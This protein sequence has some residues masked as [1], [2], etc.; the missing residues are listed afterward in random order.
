[1]SEKGASLA[2]HNPPN[3]D[4]TLTRLSVFVGKWNTEGLIKASPS[5]PAAVEIGTT[6]LHVPT[7]A[8][9]W[10][11]VNDSKFSLH[12]NSGHRIS[13]GLQS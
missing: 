3:P 4:L 7:K 9:K 10:R 12:I 1:M 6:G 13:S 2:P 8:V 11:K 5:G